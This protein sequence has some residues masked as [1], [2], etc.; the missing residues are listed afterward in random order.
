M[1]SL[2]ASVLFFIIAVFAFLADNHRVQPPVTHQ[3]A[4]V[5]VALQEPAPEQP[6]IRAAEK[7]RP[8]KKK[9]RSPV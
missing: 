1:H 3:Q 4:E 8:S 7:K 2:K 6:E 9:P 5:E